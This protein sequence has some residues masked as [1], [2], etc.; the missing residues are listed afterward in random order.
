MNNKRQTIWLVSMLSLMVILSAYY[1]FTEDVNPAGQSVGQAE[2]SQPPDSAGASVT[3]PDGVEITEV[4]PLASD[5]GASAQPTSGQA[6]SGQT[7]QD[8]GQKDA[9][10]SEQT[11][12]QA[13]QTTDGRTDGKADSEAQGAATGGDSAISP[14]DQQVLD[15]MN[16]LSGDNYFSNA[17][18]QRK[19]N[20]DK[21]F[22]KYNAI[23]SD[24]KNHT[25]DEAVAAQETLSRLQ[26]TEERINSLEEKLLVDYDNAV[27][28]EE[29]NNNFKVV[30]M[31]DKLE[32]KQAVS[33]VD[34]AVKELNVTPD[35]I[36]VRYIPPQS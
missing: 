17:Q 2:Q 23:I 15:Q 19:V 11:D 12:G 8:E 16:D 18:Y 35:R 32:K 9:A 22:E 25:Q 10:A 28:E 21:E 33:I 31:A 7:G 1:L 3:N 5:S 24:T 14:G 36:T 20:M 13:D 34:M 29:E 26:D 4:D 27:V 6:A 30:V